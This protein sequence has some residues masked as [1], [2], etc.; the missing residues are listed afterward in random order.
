MKVAVIQFPGS[1]CDLD[2]LKVMREAAHFPAELVW[3]SDFKEGKFDAAILPGGF[4]YGDHLRSGI[5]A[6][7]P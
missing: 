7:S 6:A 1:N 3:H 4:S 2:A 5:I